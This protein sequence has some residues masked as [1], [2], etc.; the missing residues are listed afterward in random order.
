MRYR[1]TLYTRTGRESENEAGW[2]KF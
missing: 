1:V 2:S